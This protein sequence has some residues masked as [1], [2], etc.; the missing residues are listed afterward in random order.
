MVDHF[1][2]PAS[3]CPRCGRRDSLEPQNYIVDVWFE[4][5]VSS[6]A[7]I[8]PAEWPPDVYL[9]GTDQYRGWFQSSLLVATQS[10]G[11]APYSTVITHGF[12]LDGEGRK[13]S[14]S[15]GNV[16]SPQEIIQKYGADILRLWVC[17]VDYLDDMRLSEEILARN[18]ETYRKIRNTCRYLLGNLYDFD[19]ARDSL[20]AAQLLE[21]DRW[22]LHQSNQVIQRCRSSYETYEFHRVYHALNHFCAVTLSY[23]Y[24]DVLKDRLYTSAPASRR[25]RSAQTALHRILDSLC[26][27]MAPV[28]SFTAEEVW[29][30][31]RKGEASHPLST[32]IHL[33]EFPAPVELPEEPQLLGRWESL[34]RVREEVL[35]HLEAARAAKQIG[36]SLEAR[37][38]LEGKGPWTALLEEYREELPSLLIVSQVELGGV[39]EGISPGVDFPELRVEIRKAQGEK[40][41][42]CWNYRLDRGSHP[43][44]PTLCGRCVAALRER[45]GDAGS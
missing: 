11:K 23:F 35:K 16:I 36:N 1:L 43:D 34:G 17:M 26:R 2:P 28:L 33:E 38:V 37:V 6:F 29:Q 39:S 24:L 30:S 12:T 5:G 7:A 8:A 10:G 27:L 42:R 9:E 4:S 31:L 32:S 45:A 25:R 44:F 3:S 15:L 19:P 20:P 21:I 40:C 18:V 22:I 13:M 41:E 14:K